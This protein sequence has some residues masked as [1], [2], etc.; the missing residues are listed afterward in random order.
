MIKRIVITGGPSSG[1]TSV[2]N[3]LHLQGY[4]CLE[5][6]SR[7]IIKERKI[8]TSFKDME[9]EEIVFNKR[10]EQFLNASSPIQFYD[11]SILDGLAYL[12]INQL[13]TPSHFL[14][15]VNTHKYFP[16][17]FIAPPWKEI[18]KQ[19][20]ER[21]EE[22]EDAIKVYHSLKEVYTKSGYELIDLPLTS[23][24]KRIEFILDR[25]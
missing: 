16:K 22:F 21:L 5:E 20:S 3:Q 10:I 13:Q 12:K 11:R 17:V 23:I 8:K 25:I 7:E 2:I 6:V 15:Q 24:D 4:K 9:F 14:N 19:D 1:K 18:Y